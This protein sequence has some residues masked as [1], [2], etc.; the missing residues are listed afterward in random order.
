MAD[1]VRHRVYKPMTT[2]TESFRDPH[3]N[4]LALSRTKSGMTV[5]TGR[6]YV[7]YYELFGNFIIRQLPHRLRR[8][9]PSS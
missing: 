6:K 4:C 1:P 2:I 8:S 9:P 5:F 3:H 7:E